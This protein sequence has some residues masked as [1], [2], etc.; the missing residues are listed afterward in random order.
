L[1]RFDNP[2]PLALDQSRF[3]GRNIL[4][5]AI[6]TKTNYVPIKEE[7]LEKISDNLSKL[8]QDLNISDTESDHYEEMIPRDFENVTIRSIMPVIAVKK[9]TPKHISPTESHKF[10]MFASSGSQRES[11]DRFDT[12]NAQKRGSELRMVLHHKLNKIGSPTRA[13]VHPTDPHQQDCNQQEK[14]P[15]SDPSLMPIQKTLNLK[16]PTDSPRSIS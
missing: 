6:S 3:T 10:M 12:Q 9:H 15:E 11:M 4:L 5:D 7:Q 14:H 2:S 16:I 8:C 1:V 13:R